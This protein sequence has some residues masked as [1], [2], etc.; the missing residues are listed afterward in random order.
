[1]PEV[2]DEDFAGFASAKLNIPVDGIY[3]FGFQGDDGGYL[4]IPGG[5]FT[6]IVENATGNAV[7]DE[8][9]ARIN[10][11]CLTGNSRTIGEIFL[12]AGVHD[13]EALFLERGGGNYWEVFASGPGGLDSYALLT[14]GAAGVY[15]DF[16]GIQLVPEPSTALLAL[17][18]LV[19]LAFAR[20]R[21]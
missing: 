20:R 14:T 7:I 19:G 15:E 1:V 17:L 16:D 2:N 13:I 6:S 4:R 11:D 8:G 18:G 9:G 12:T 10:C 5:T 3:R 21:K